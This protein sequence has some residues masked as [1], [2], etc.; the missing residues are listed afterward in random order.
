MGH[1][2]T[3]LAWVPRFEHHERSSTVLIRVVEFVRG[4]LRDLLYA[5]DPL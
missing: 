1:L 3:R 5:P 2:S 4:G